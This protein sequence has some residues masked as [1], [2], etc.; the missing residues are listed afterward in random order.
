[1][2]SVALKHSRGAGKTGPGSSG[3][4]MH[5]I[6]AGFDAGTGTVQRIKA[7]MAA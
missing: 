5:N 2:R 4:G 3:H 1:M 7:E 6:A